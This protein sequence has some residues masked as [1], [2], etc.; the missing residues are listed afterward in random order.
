MLIIHVACFFLKSHLK[1]K[2]SYKQWASH[3]SLHKNH[4]KTTICPVLEW[5]LQEVYIYMYRE[6]E[7]DIG[8]VQPKLLGSCWLSCLKPVLSQVEPKTLRVF[9]HFR[10]VIAR[11]ILGG[12]DTW[13]GMEWP[14]LSVSIHKHQIYQI[15]S[16]KD[17]GGW[18]RLVFPSMGY[19]FMRYGPI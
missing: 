14:W 19:E 6:R 18:T 5:F 3:L 1:T 16:H 13:N 10:E 4:L 8:A 7:R 11:S 15:H 2:P 9:S 12:V 17:V